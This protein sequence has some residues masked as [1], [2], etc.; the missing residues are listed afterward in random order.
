MYTIGT[1][2]ELCCVA[3]LSKPSRRK[4][5]SAASRSTTPMNVTVCSHGIA[6]WHGGAPSYVRFRSIHASECVR[7]G[8]QGSDPPARRRPQARAAEA[9]QARAHARARARGI[10]YYR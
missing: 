8:M 2:S 9:N 6:G 5:A 1:L 7:A 10:S 4:N 3:T